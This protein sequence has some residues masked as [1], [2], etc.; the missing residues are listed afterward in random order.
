[1]KVHKK[2]YVAESSDIHVRVIEIDDIYMKETVFSQKSFDG[3][4]MA[5]L[6]QGEFFGLCT[7]ASS[8]FKVTAI[9]EL[10][11]LDND[12]RGFKDICTLLEKLRPPGHKFVIDHYRAEAERVALLKKR[13]DPGNK[14]WTRKQ[15]Y[16][17]WYLKCK[18]K[19]AAA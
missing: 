13:Q 12:V 15:E 10:H 5:D 8:K 1:M 16:W 17:P 18:L 11:A 2:I 9:T 3:V 19:D 14:F 7:P 4:N 6:I